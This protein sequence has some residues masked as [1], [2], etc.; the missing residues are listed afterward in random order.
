MK[1]KLLFVLLLTATASCDY[2]MPKLGTSKSEIAKV[3][4]K[5]LEGAIQLFSDD[6]ARYPATAEGLEALTHR[7]DNL[8]GWN[9]P[10]IHK[11]VPNDPWGRAY[12]YKCPGDKFLW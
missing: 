3:Q 11:R 9:G 6:L 2:V 5:E 8:H 12:I 4:I 7:P 10:Y 1:E